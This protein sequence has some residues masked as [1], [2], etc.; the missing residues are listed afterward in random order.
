[1]YDGNVMPK[2]YPKLY[3][4][5]EIKIKKIN[6]KKKIL[7]IMEPIMEKFIPLEEK[8]EYNFSW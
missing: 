6:L 2:G 3:K 4:N 1:M 8:F 7:S 5:K